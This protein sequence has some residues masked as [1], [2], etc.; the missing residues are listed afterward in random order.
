MSQA[1]CSQRMHGILP[2]INMRTRSFFSCVFLLVSPMQHAQQIF[3][4]FLAIR[5]QS[6]KISPLEHFSVK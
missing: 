6:I 4:N 5:M 3:F 2:V 1:F